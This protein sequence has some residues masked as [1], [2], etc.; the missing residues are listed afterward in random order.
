MFGSF[1]HRVIGGDSQMLLTSCE[2]AT[3]GGH[4]ENCSTL[5]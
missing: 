4:T 5:L 1:V 2:N 3:P